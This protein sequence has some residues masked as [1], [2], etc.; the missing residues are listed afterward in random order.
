MTKIIKTIAFLLVLTG[1][2]ALGVST[3]AKAPTISSHSRVLVIQG[4]VE[5]NGT[6]ITPDMVREGPR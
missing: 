5:T 6:P 4:H 2:L 1:L 3:L